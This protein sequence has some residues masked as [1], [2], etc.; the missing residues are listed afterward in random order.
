MH[1]AGKFAEHLYD[2]YLLQ[3]P[4]EKGKIPE[5]EYIVEIFR[6]AGLFHDIGHGPLG[7]TLDD[8]YVKLDYKTDHE[9]IGKG[10]IKTELA[11]L[12]RNIKR[13]PNGEFSKSIEPDILCEYIKPSKPAES[14]LE[15]S[16]RHIL[17]GMFSAD[18]LDF[19]VRDAY[20][21]GTKEYGSIDGERLIRSS[22][23]TKE[24]FT[25]HKSAFPALK[26][27]LW[28]RLFMF[29]NVYYHRTVRAFDHSFA[30]LL[31]EII[32]ILNLGNPQTNLDGFFNLT[33]TW[34]H[35]SIPL[36]LLDEN[37]SK[38]RIGEQWTDFTQKRKCLW[39]A[40]DLGAPQYDY[41]LSRGEPTLILKPDQVK[42]SL[43]ENA[44]SVL[45]VDQQRYWIDVPGLDVRPENPFPRPPED[46]TERETTAF[47]VYDPNTEEIETASL[48]KLFKN[49]P[50]RFI[51]P[52]I[53]TTSEFIDVV[54]SK[55]PQ[56]LGVQEASPPHL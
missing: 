1:L 50:S 22:F 12:V 39:H 15:K 5:R 47:Y 38:K 7:H 4:E 51:G 31:K 30:E 13:S 28:S 48:E 54:R 41:S 24:G 34:L 53:Y 20:F 56:I 36:W 25:V 29:E 40:I 17:R 37:A 23:I 55:I 42:R 46:Q 19:L 2:Q 10:I 11:D 33:D 43:E 49:V 8:I 52:R 21:C 32:K 14:L 27:F 35:S 16:L 26:A 44:S 3:F 45:S 18:K 9:L 6:L